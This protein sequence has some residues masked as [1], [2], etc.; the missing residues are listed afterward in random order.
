M[1]NPTTA[2]R[3]SEIEAFDAYLADPT[4]EN[5]VQS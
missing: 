5:E 1:T 4:P 3:L 2:A